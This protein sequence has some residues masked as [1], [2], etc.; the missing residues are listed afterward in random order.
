VKFRLPEIV[1]RTMQDLHR[2]RPTQ[3]LVKAV[4]RRQQLDILPCC[5]AGGNGVGETV[6]ASP[7]LASKNAR[8]CSRL[9]FSPVRMLTINSQHAG[10]LLQAHLL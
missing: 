2:G 9:N 1:A 7:S 6:P 3:C 5:I 8:I 4:H 10:S